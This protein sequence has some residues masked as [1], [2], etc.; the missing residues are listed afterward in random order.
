MKNRDEKTA[1]LLRSLGLSDKEAAIYL[2]ILEL[3]K[4]GVSHIGRRTGVNRTT[5]YAV[6]DSLAGKGLVSISGKEP[7]EEYA[8]EPPDNLV[9]Y[10]KDKLTDAEH[11]TE[12]V[13]HGIERA[14]ELLPHLK[15]I[16]KVGDRP[17]VRFYDGADGLK[18][19]YE[20]TLTST[21]G[22]RAFASFED[23]AA[24]LSTFYPT[25]IKRRAA[26]RIF[27]RGIVPRT[28]MSIE[29]KSHDAEEYRELVLLPEEKP[30]LYPEIDVYGNKVMIA[31]E[32]EKLG[33]IIESKEIA[34]AMK[35]IFDL[36][37]ERAKQLET[38]TEV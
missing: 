38:I 28:P 27:S 7:K 30:S 37:W 21:D 34:L 29:R 14:E 9:A 6:L 23:M 16:H 5:V 15:A 2:A 12:V 8:A 10:L 33:I 4:A 20:D 36:A 13:K 11:H 1:S 31:S 25:Y 24:S 18:H 17:R 22:I 26:Q 32:R 19:V 3:G 35:K